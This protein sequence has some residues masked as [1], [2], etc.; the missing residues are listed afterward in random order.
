MI[1]TDGSFDVCWS[2]L[3]EVR[4]PSDTE[5]FEVIGHR[6]AVDAERPSDL[7]QRMTVLVLVSYAGNLRRGQSTLNWLRWSSRSATCGGGVDA[8]DVGTERLG[9]GV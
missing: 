7:V 2:Q 4:P 8:I 5:V 1:L 6:L 9:A 3:G